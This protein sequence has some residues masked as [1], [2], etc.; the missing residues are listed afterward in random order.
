MLVENVH[1]S[2][3]SRTL[4]GWYIHPIPYEMSIKEFFYKLVID[5]ISLE[6][7]IPISPFEIIKRVE[8]S[9][10]LGTTAF[11]ASSNCKIIESTKTF[12]V[13]IYYHLKHSD[14]ITS[15]SAP[16]QNAFELLMQSQKGQK[17]L[18]TVLKFKQLNRKQTLYNDIIEWICQNGGGWSL[19]EDANAQRKRF[20]NCLCKAIW[21]IDMHGHL[22]L[23]ERSYHIPELFLVFFGHANSESY[24]E[25]WKPFNAIELNLHC[26]ALASHTMSQ[27]MLKPSFNWLREPYNN[28]ITTILNY[29]SFLQKQNRITTENHA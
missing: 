26:Q 20:V 19:A 23:K 8:L 9:Q 16:F 2:K 17:F 22:K 28:L 14:I 24:K 1:I 10:A 12:G 18:P 21:Y 7:N 11:Q 4:H 13:N 6:C 5:E 25:S 3:G 15:H 29:V 27:W